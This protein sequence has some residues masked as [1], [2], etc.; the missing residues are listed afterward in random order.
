[1]TSPDDERARR[2]SIARALPLLIRGTTTVPSV[3]GDAD[4][5]LARLAASVLQGNTPVHGPKE[6]VTA[7]GHLAIAGRLGSQGATDIAL[8]LDDRHEALV[9][10]DFD[11]AWRLWLH[12]S[13]L[14]GWRDEAETF[15]ITTVSGVAAGTGIGPIDLPLH[16]LSAEW[17]DA[18]TY[19]TPAERKLLARFAQAG[20]PLPMLGAET[21]DGLVLSFTWADAKVAVAWDVT[22]EDRA[23]TAA[24]GWTVFD[25]DDTG[26]E[27]LVAAV[28]GN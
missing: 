13:N 22:D 7:H 26:V 5:S 9:A 21:R 6:W 14:V 16:E 10:D 27:T 18:A 2:G 12:L 23:V 15:T 1:M 3:S 24:E 19:A 25:A 11:R 20:L 8:V 17:A 4:T 28:G